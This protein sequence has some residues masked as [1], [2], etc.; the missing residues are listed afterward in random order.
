MV[1]SSFP[2]VP[3]MST[4]MNSCRTPVAHRCM[5]GDV[6]ALLCLDEDVRHA[7]DHRANREG[8]CL[9]RATFDSNTWQPVVRPDK[10]PADQRNA[11]FVKLQQAV[12]NK[13][14][15]GYIVETVATLEAIKKVDRLNISP[16]VGQPWRSKSQWRAGRA[17]RR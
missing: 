3:I 10:F 7:E 13:A 1:A 17:G 16:A 12:K 4:T 11:D 9:V 14:I 15:L 2:S 6:P 5:R 8:W